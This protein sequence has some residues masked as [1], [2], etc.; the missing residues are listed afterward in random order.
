LA[1][2]VLAVD[3][4]CAPAQKI[5][6]SINNRVAVERSL[7][8]C[9]ATEPCRAVPPP[10]PAPPAQPLPPPA[11]AQ[12]A[13][14]LFLQAVVPPAPNGPPAPDR[15]ARPGLEPRAP[16]SATASGV[17][18]PVRNA[19]GDSR[20]APRSGRVLWPDEL[21]SP[22]LLPSGLLPRAPAHASGP[23]RQTDRRQA[24]P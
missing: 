3:P 23:S 18:G 6:D 22:G 20:S 12:P 21:L 7:V 15:S 13:A 10:L 2:A 5:I 14:P 17:P 8:R 9:A 1:R 19:A 4:Q 16:G 24:G 11:A